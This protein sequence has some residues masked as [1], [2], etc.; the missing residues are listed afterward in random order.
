MKRLA[1]AGALFLLGSL[2]WADPVTL[3]LV[4]STTQVVTGEPVTLDVVIAGLGSPGAMEVGSFDMY[5]GFDPSL[6]T[7]TGVTFTSLLGDPSKGQAITTYAFGSYWVEAVDVS[8]LPVQQLDQMQPP[9]FTLATYDFTA[10]AS[11]T[12]SF[13]YLGGPVDNGYG[14]LIA[15]SKEGPVPE[16]PS[17]LLFLSGLVVS[18]CW[19]FWQR[20]LRA[21]STRK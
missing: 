7:P 6:L 14:Q 16:P 17:I 4:P 15:G 10:L 21:V 18:G 8:L 1:W 20:G 3:T 5:V 19:R 13:D 2:L 11:G 12:I 9:S